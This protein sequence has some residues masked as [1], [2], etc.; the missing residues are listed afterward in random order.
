MAEPHI[1]LVEDDKSLATWIGDYLCG[2]GFTVTTLHRGDQVID[3]LHSVKPD[4]TILDLMLPGKSGLQVC[5][6][7]RQFYRN[8]I[9]ML[10]ACSDESDEIMGL[11]V[12]ADDYLAKPV[13]PKILLARLRVLLRREHVED[14][15][16]SSAELRFGQLRILQ[17]AKSVFW[18]DQAVGL[19]SHEFDLLWQLA[20]QAGKVVSRDSLVKALR[21][22]DYDGLDR[23]ID[24]R[25]SRL[26]K[27]L[28]DSAQ[29]PFRIK[30]V[31][32]KGY[33]FVP[34][35]WVS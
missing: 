13:R 24:I 11:D 18:Q 10:T 21:G 27:K 22:I 20:S 3:A 19:T 4:L 14:T 8:P 5:Q 29:E 15:V 6:E 25:I 7:A 16:V 17:D 33:L 31:W 34:E 23:S 32:S 2:Q 12:G 26:R 28:H 35:A 30:T 1:L 9:V